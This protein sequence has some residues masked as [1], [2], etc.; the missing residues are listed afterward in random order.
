METSFALLALC[1]GKSP[2]TG[3]FP[4]HR[5]VTRNYDAF[6]D[7]HLNG[8]LRHHRAHYDVTVMRSSLGDACSILKII[9]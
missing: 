2:D 1:S 6:F 7:L 5:P 4:A 3:E 8:D 9:D